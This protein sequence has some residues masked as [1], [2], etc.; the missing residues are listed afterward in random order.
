MPKMTADRAA[1]ILRRLESFAKLER[2][3]TDEVGWI[4]LAYSVTRPQAAKMIEEAQ[5]LAGS[6]ERREP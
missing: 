4:A 5:R 3:N 6:P 2:Q 1:T